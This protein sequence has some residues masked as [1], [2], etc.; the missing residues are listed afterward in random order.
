MKKTLITLL[1]AITLIFCMVVSVSAETNSD[2]IGIRGDADM[3]GTINVKDATLVQK[4]VAS[5]VEFDASQTAC[6]DSDENGT[7]NVKDATMIQ[8]YVADIEINQPTFA[9]PI[10]T[11]GNTQPTASATASTEPEPTTITTAPTQPVVDKM[12]TNITI[13]FSNNQKWSKVNAYLYNEVA[14]TQNAE[15]PGEAMKLHSTNDYGEQIYMMDVDVSEFNRVVFNNGT[16]QSM[17]ASLSVASSGFY[18]AKNTPKNSMP[19]GLYAFN[20]TDYGKITK[21]TLDYPDG[22]KKPI[23]IWTPNGYDPADTDTKYPV[24][25]LLDGQNQFLGTTNGYG[26]WVTDKIAT[27]LQSNGHKGFILV[28]IDNSRNRDKELT[29]DIGDV[30]PAYKNVFE[31]G[32]GETFSNFVAND[33]MDYVKSN[34]NVSDKPEDNAIIGSSSGGIEAFYIGMENMDKFGRI[35]SISPAFMLFG[36]SD[37]DTYLAKFDFTDADKL[38]RIYFFNGYA[39][40]LEKELKPYAEAMPQWMAKLGYPEDK[41][42]FVL[43]DTFSHN[44]YAWRMIMPEIIAW[45]FEL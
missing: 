17:N 11:P 41:M 8:K 1:A 18:I 39:D 6:A 13:Y 28:G 3:N 35:G 44:E 20:E 40:S 19:L 14:G 16:S 21:I 10:Y 5:M 27:C 37:W 29:P 15:W 23:Q 22:Y 32:V 38:P 42:T 34:Y 33:V 24:I 45:L 2:I 31:N 43:E 4:Q 7:I 30:I 25:Y 9:E 36:K 26:G 12:D